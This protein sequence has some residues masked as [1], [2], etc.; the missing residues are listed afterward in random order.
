M[1][2]RERAYDAGGWAE[3]KHEHRAG[4]V[5]VAE[6]LSRSDRCESL[7]GYLLRLGVRPDSLRRSR[8]AP[9]ALPARGPGKEETSDK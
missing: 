5:A 6:R 9:S 7:L 2:A 8:I 1:D 4:S 3:Q